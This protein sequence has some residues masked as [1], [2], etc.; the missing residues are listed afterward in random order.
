MFKTTY[1]G[2]TFAEKK[3]HSTQLHI[4]HDQYN[5]RLL[6]ILCT[7][8]GTGIYIPINTLYIYYE[9]KK[10]PIF[11]T[12]YNTLST[13]FLR[14]IFF[15]YIFFSIS[16][17]PGHI[18]G[19]IECNTCSIEKSFTETN[20]QIQLRSL[21]WRSFLWHKTRFR[22]LGSCRFVVVAFI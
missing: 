17:R 6:L 9:Q 1:D 10:M 16:L 11:Q 4:F 19:R 20:R 14:K 5:F 8:H 2:I 18:A 12:Q 22:R 7:I 15:Q 3:N 13:L 21:G